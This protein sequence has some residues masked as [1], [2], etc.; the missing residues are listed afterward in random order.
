MLYFAEEVEDIISKMKS[1][2]SHVKQERNIRRINKVHRAM[3]EINSFVSKAYEYID[4]LD[5]VPYY[6]QCTYHGEDNDS[7]YEK[8][9]RR[10]VKGCENLREC[11]EI[12]ESLKSYCRNAQKSCD[13]AA[14]K[15]E[16]EAER[17]RMIINTA[18]RHSK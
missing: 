7:E 5:D 17:T 11:L 4:R 18:C 2:L 1:L 6:F 9:K 13:Q 14:E 3:S 12:N 16:E 10:L 8:C 15:L